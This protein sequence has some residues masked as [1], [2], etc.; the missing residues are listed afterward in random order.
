MQRMYRLKQPLV[1]SDIFT[2]RLNN[3]S[4]DNGLIFSLHLDQINASVLL[5]GDWDE[6]QIRIYRR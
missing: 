2:Y 3:S 4:T 6:K 1:L 5:E